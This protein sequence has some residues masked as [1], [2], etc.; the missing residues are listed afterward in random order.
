VETGF[1]CC[2]ET[3]RIKAEYTNAPSNAHKILVGKIELKC[4]RESSIKLNI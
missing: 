2:I 4:G 1:L 3:H